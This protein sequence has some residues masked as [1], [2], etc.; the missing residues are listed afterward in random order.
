M[1]THKA[2]SDFQRNKLNCLGRDST[3]TARDGAR[4][5]VSVGHTAGGRRSSC[6][7]LCLAVHGVHGGRTQHRADVGGVARVESAHMIQDQRHQRKVEAGNP[8]HLPLWGG[9]GDGMEER[10]GE[11]GGGGEMEERGDHS[12]WVRSEVSVPWTA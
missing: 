3:L 6:D 2:A 11:G 4:Q 8:G 10:G 9:G 7:R 12:Q 5:G 1:H